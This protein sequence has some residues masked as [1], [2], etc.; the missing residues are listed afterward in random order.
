[1]VAEQRKQERT[2]KRKMEELH[3]ANLQQYEASLRQDMADPNGGKI[4]EAGK[5]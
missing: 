1:M 5:R 2:L 4:S 3:F